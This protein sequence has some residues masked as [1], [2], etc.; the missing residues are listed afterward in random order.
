M[1]TAI[2]IDEYI[3]QGL[4][5][6]QA[7]DLQQAENLYH[8]ALEIDENCADA[9]H[10]LGMLAFDIQNL[11]VAKDLVLHAIDLD[12]SSPI[13]YN[14]LGNIMMHGGEFM[15]AQ[16]YFA[17][18]I[19]L[20][21]DYTEAHYN[22]GNALIAQGKQ[23]EAIDS[24][25]RSIELNN[26][27]TPAYI[28]LGAVYM[29][30]EHFD[31]ALIL[32]GKALDLE[33][34]NPAI[35]SELS[36]ALLAKGL[37]ENETSPGNGLPYFERACQIDTSNSE[38]HMAL[39]DYHLNR[40]DIDQAKQ[41]YARG[42]EGNPMNPDL[43]YNLAIINKQ[44]NNLSEA[45][46]RFQQAIAVAPQHLNAHYNLANTLKELGDWEQALEHYNAA[47]SLDSSHWPSLVN[48]GVVQQG[49][50]LFEES[51]TTLQQAA[52]INAEDHQL[53]N[54]IGMTLHSL[55][56]V[57]EALKHYE[58]ALQIAPDNPET[59]WN[60]SLAL[61]ANGDY[62]EGWKL[63]ER[64]W[65][66]NEKLHNR[67]PAFS[68]DQWDGS[69][70]NGRNILVTAE[71]GYGDSIQFVRFASMLKSRGAGNVIVQCQSGLETLFTTV[72]GID[73]IITERQ[74][75]AESSFDIWCPMMSLPHFFHTTLD[76]IP[77]EV[78]YADADTALVEDWSDRLRIISGLKI[79]IVWAGN[80]RKN[81]IA[82]NLIDSR[83][84]CKLADFKPLSNIDG[85]KLI[86]LQKGEAA[87]QTIIDN[88][89]V[90]V[91]DHTHAINSFADTAAL[92]ENLDLVISVDT[93]V[94]HLAGAMNKPVWLLSRFDACWRWL[95]E[96]EDS[97]WY[98]SM[99]VFRQSRPGD[100]GELMQ[101]VAKALKEESK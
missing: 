68:Q 58:H 43:Y 3:A 71:Q 85:I 62:E 60:K 83:R 93:S 41:L 33:P 51:L 15:S 64:R 32:F 18:A 79:G 82:N 54:N 28:N 96:G 98:P 95:R 80:P 17:K 11:E 49:L 31:N 92:I 69:D 55:G 20:K 94:V 21:S 91:I 14:N 50:G 67:K 89:G 53:Q 38:A 84:S 16:E 90:S 40:G 65:E 59:Q 39:A 74:Q 37:Q 23:E 97:P 24:L 77:N 99:R 75:P 12:N 56:R 25:K 70:L 13:Y 73:E 8:K 47:L 7:G 9:Y 48:K 6:H 35:V 100:W 10:L 1:N 26:N 44:Q 66:L 81:D 34:Q 30:R 46:G 36:N 52:G 76:S 29:E 86:S 27:F 61:L 22:L 2:S 78:P 45:S 101:R 4:E 88:G 57:D 19:E 87:I 72:K 5:K 42:I 63:Y